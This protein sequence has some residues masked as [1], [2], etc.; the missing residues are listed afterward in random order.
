MLQV[1]EMQVGVLVGFDRR[2][3]GNQ[4]IEVMQ[5]DYGARLCYNHP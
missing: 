1:S 3:F 2:E 4:D 5:L